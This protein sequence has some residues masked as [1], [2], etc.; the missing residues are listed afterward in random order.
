MAKITI[1][2]TDRPNE[3]YA[4]EVDP[5]MAET[6][7][8]LKKNGTLTSAEAAAVHIIN[9]VRERAKV[10]SAEARAEGKTLTEGEPGDQ[11]QPNQPTTQ[12]LFPTRRGAA[13]Q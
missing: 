11:G 10:A 7:S 13:P 5:P 9:G 1:T 2:I 8:N 3:M 12:V 6:L 4:I